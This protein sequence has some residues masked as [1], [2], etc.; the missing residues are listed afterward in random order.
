MTKLLLTHAGHIVFVIGGVVAFFLAAYRKP[1]Q[2]AAPGVL[3]P[4][5]E[6]P[7]PALVRASVPVARR[8]LLA[9]GPLLA[10]L[11]TG[12]VLY[13]MNVG[14]GA[15]SGALVWGHVGVSV[16]ALLLVGYKLAS[17]RGRRIVR[18]ALTRGRLAELASLALGA[19]FVPIV[20][21]GIAL[22]V[23]PSGGSF[24]AYSH[25]VASAWWT[26]L[27][28]WHLRRYVGPALRAVAGRPVEP[29]PAVAPAQAVAPAPAPSAAP[30]LPHA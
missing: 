4:A 22:V 15:V 26:G 9:L 6:A 27:L 8:A 11:G 1:S 20:I 10:A 13:G 12:A 21:S 18:R 16:L 3:P 29:A 25:L 5:P 7:T 19:L 30:A 23:A 17:M 2:P 14:G 28:L 24:A